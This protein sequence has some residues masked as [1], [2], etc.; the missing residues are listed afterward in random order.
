[1]GDGAEVASAGTSLTLLAMRYAD[2]LFASATGATVDIV[3][4]DMADLRRLL[5]ESA[6][7]RTAVTNPLFTRAE[8]ASALAAVAEQAGFS[9]LTRRF[10][11]VVAANHRLAALDAIAAAYLADVAKRR[12]EMTVEVTSAR[13]LTPAQVETVT[14]GLNQA[15][16]AKTTLALQVDPAL[17][18]GLTI[19]VGSQLIDASLKSRLDRLGHVLKTAA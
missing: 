14:S 5:A 2:A 9:D 16:A 18:G 1:M 3:A 4:R 10:I 12:G 17:L 8:Q 7:L 19:R 6:D 15:L 11:G 13:P